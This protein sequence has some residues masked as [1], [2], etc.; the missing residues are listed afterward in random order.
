MVD[1]MRDQNQIDE[2]LEDRYVHRSFAN[3]EDMANGLKINRFVYY[4]IGPSGT[5]KQPRFKCSI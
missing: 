4:F 1:E 2:K 3:I 5:G